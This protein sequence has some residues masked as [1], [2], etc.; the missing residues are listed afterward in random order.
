MNWERRKDRS[1]NIIE[2]GT[3]GGLAVRGQT[4]NGGERGGVVVS[5]GRKAF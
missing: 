5:G 4:L 1:I 2:A 3:L